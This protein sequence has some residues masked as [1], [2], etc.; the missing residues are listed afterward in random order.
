MGYESGIHALCTCLLLIHCNIYAPCE[1]Y[2]YAKYHIKKTTA[3]PYDNQN[4][5]ADFWKSNPR[6]FCDF[7]RCWFADNKISIAIHENGTKHK[8]AVE[9]RLK[10]ARTKQKQQGADQA[11]LRRQLKEIEEEALK[12]MQQDIHDNPELARADSTYASLTKKRPSVGFT[13]DPSSTDHIP[14]TDWVRRKTEDGL[15]YYHNMLTGEASWDHPLS[16]S[17]TGEG[18]EGQGQG[19]GGKHPNVDRYTPAEKKKLMRRL[20][21][22]Q[23]SSEGHPYYYNTVTMASQWEKPSDID[24]RVPYDP[25]V[26]GDPGVL[27][28]RAF[29]NDFADGEGEKKKNEQDGHAR[30]TGD[31]NEPTAKRARGG[32]GEEGEEGGATRNRDEGGIVHEKLNEAELEKVGGPGMGEVQVDGAYPPPELTSLMRWE[33]VKS[34]HEQERDERELE[35]DNDVGEDE[36]VKNSSEP[37]N[38]SGL[39]G[40]DNRGG[41]SGVDIGKQTKKITEQVMDASRKPLSF[42]LGTAKAEAEGAPSSAST[43]SASI[44]FHSTHTTATAIPSSTSSSST[45]A[46]TLAK[47]AGLTMYEQKKLEPEFVFESKATPVLKLPHADKDIAI[48]AK[49]ASGVFRQR[50]R[51]AF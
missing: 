12:K 49:K 31:F 14:G 35:M 7:C 42:S 29:S 11:E 10:D 41:A 45:P 24:A 39:K 18:G 26:D 1:V 5:M 44:G 34:D 3:V 9:K 19:G 47:K 36:G 50:I 8:E 46:S 17:H 16:G 2:R 25:D 30:G 33:R 22:E 48:V 28:L 20:W 13:I 43:S 38:A 23:M 32:N 21:L 37:N 4:N 27:A 6:K 40:N 51:K 15:E